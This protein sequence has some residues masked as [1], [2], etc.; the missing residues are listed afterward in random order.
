MTDLGEAQMF[1]KALPCHLKG[2]QRVGSSWEARSTKGARLFRRAWPGRLGTQDSGC[3]F[4]P[5]VRFLGKTNNLK[6]TP[7]PQ[8]RHNFL[9]RALWTGRVE[10]GGETERQP[11]CWNSSRDQSWNYWTKLFQN[12]LLL[13]GFPKHCVHPSPSLTP[14]EYLHLL[15]DGFSYLLSIELL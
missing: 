11:R 6:G 3:C 8:Q 9:S 5:C 10:L 14:V 2:Q 12:H 15:K 7:L 13:W 1:W 4:M